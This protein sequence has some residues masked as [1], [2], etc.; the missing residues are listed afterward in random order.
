MIEEILKFNKEFVQKKKY[1]EFCTDKYPNKKVA[2]LSCMDTRLTHLL[3]A[4]LGLKNGDAKII[5]N[6]GAEI[7]NDYGSTIKSLLVA[8]YDLG[9]KEVLVIGHDDCGI[10]QLDAKEII[11]KMIAR[12]VSSEEIERIDQRE[13]ALGPYLTGFRDV[14]HSVCTT[15]RRI[16]RHPLIPRDITVVG[17][18]MNP[19]TGEVRLAEE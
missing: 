12:G 5:K 8:I 3:P 7:N 1:Q 6:A 4:A 2:I 9:V 18:I 19:D 15:V 13:C 16:L 14:N 11:K 17:L 10:Q